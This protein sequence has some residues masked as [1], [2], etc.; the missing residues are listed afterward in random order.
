MRLSWAEWQVAAT[1]NLPTLCRHFAR[2]VLPRRAFVCPRDGLRDG[3]RRIG[4]AS[5][6]GVGRQRSAGSYA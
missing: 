5:D 4:A 1:A 6:P 2:P 3:A